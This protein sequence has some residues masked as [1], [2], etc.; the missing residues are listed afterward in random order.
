M[1]RGIE[2]RALLLT[3]VAHAPVLAALC[4]IMK[5][6]AKVAPTPVGC[7]AVIED[8]NSAPAAAS[9]LSAHLPQAGILLLRAL[10]QQVDAQMWLAGELH[11][12]P[13]PGVIFNETPELIE[14][15]LLGQISVADLPQVIDSS[16]IGRFS[17]LRSLRKVMK[18]QKKQAPRGEG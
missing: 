18:E 17:A 14:Q 2:P 6:S 9:T 15:Y 16:Q 1:T 13:S 11:D 4:S 7:I 12:R 5:I 8:V 3:E 10:D